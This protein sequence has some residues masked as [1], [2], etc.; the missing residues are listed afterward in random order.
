MF[1]NDILVSD[2]GNGCI[3]KISMALDETSVVIGNKMLTNPAGMIPV[4]L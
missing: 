1:G 3:R 4:K 2:S